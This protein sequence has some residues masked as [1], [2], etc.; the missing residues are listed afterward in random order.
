VT[1]PITDIVC[2]NAAFAASNAAA[3]MGANFLI[4]MSAIQ[5]LIE[6]L[7]QAYY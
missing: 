3:I 1:C 4:F 5:R 7:E 6:S 2:P